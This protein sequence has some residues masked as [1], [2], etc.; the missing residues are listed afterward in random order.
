L[1]AT[2]LSPGTDTV[3]LEILDM[4]KNVLGKASKDYRIL[5]EINYQFPFFM[6][7]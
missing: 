2:A 6:N 7:N 1:N 5:E 3:T 4:N